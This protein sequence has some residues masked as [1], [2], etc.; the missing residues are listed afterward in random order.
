MR[1]GEILVPEYTTSKTECN[2]PMGQEQVIRKIIE[3]CNPI[4]D[5]GNYIIVIYNAANKR[6]TLKIK[7][8]KYLIATDDAG[9][10]L[11]STQFRQDLNIVKP[12]Y[13][14]IFH[15]Y[16]DRILRKNMITKG[17]DVFRTL[18]KLKTNT[19]SKIVDDIME[20]LDIRATY[21]HHYLLPPEKRENPYHLM[22]A[23][24]RYA[25]YSNGDLGYFCDVI[26]TIC[27]YEKP[28]LGYADAI[29]GHTKI[30]SKIATLGERSS[31]GII[32][33]SIK[34]E[35]FAS[36]AK[37][38]FKLPGDYI[39]PF[40]FYFLRDKFR[41]EESFEAHK[42]VINELKKGFPDAFDIAATFIGGFFG[43]KTFYDDYYS[44]LPIMVNSKK[45]EAKLIFKA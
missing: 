14:D 34:N 17:I 20:G 45:K 15:E 16:N 28:E 10:H 19:N 25:P 8:V 12:V 9:Y 1:Y 27:Y 29:A 44:K 4:S 2:T 36:K 43:Y 3:E 6:N 23:Y 35:Q 33:G 37:E 39:V 24:D 30:Y 41:Q 32:V 38:I 18:C 22:I 26:E 5:P 42:I 7:N 11:F 31:A 40:I 21:R 13:A